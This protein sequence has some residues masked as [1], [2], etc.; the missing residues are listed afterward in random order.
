MRT[1]SGRLLGFLF[2]LPALFAQQDRIAG[3][4][5]SRSLVVLIPTRGRGWNSIADPS[6]LRGVSREL[7]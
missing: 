3:S 7:L 6:T 1:I 5:D 2:L 4:I